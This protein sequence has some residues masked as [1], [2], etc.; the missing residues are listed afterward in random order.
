MDQQTRQTF[1]VLFPG[2]KLYS[3]VDQ[4]QRLQKNSKH[5]SAKNKREK[6]L[7]SNHFQINSK[8]L[9]KSWDGIKSVVTLKSKAKTSPMSCSQI[10]IF[11]Q[12]KISSLRHLIF[13]V[14]AGSNLAPKIPKAKKILVST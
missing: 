7:I 14:N 11:L 10:E 12:I 3:Y 5:C 4:V 2:N 8:N 13:F 9:K 1:Q 6:I